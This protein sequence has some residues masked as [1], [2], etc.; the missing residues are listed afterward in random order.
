MAIYKSYHGQLSH[1]L[2]T[3]KKFV[4]EGTLHFYEHAFC[5][6]LVEGGISGE[7]L[8]DTYY[9]QTLYNILFVYYLIFYHL[10]IIFSL[11]ADVVLFNSH[12][13]MDSFLKSVDSFLKLIPDHKPQGISEQIQSK[14]SVLYFPLQF[15]FPLLSE[16]VT[17][18]SQTIPTSKDL[19][20]TESHQGATIVES[21]PHIAAAN[22]S[23]ETCSSLQSPPQE[24]LCVELMHHSDD[25][26]P[27]CSAR[28]KTSLHIVWPHRW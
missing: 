12:F 16:K 24:H 3:V 19:Y 14:C 20:I 17:L 10:G 6:A 2:V 25:S 4:W 21:L 1:S 8:P 9:Y 7:M 26:T 11:V 5:T 15:P 23:T 18:D 22:N 28:V 27:V 13:N